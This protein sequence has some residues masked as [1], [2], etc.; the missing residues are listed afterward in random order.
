MAAQS[1]RNCCCLQVWFC[2]LCTWNTHGEMC[3]SVECVCVP[4]PVLV[5]NPVLWAGRQSCKMGVCW[6]LDLSIP[7]NDRNITLRW[8]SLPPD[9]LCPCHKELNT[10]EAAPE[11]LTSNLAFWETWYPR[12]CQAKG[13]VCR[14][15][16]KPLW[17]PSFNQP[18]LFVYKDI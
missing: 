2:S 5:G 4:A 17:P 14:G 11:T 6:Q 16:Q 13:G 8:S 9:L 3:W 15:R 10:C 7:P 1:P 12:N 18:Y